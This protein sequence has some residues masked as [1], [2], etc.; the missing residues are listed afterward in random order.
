MAAPELY[1]VAGVGPGHAPALAA[2]LTASLSAAPVASV[3]LTPAEGGTLD[4]QSV[5]PL[6]D[7]VQ[8]KGVAVLIA[9]DADLA[10]AVRAD[11]V[12]LSWSRNQI[13]RYAQARETLG[14]R[15]I[16][17]A[18]AGRSRDDAMT[19]GESGADYVA[20]GI[21]PH[22]ED[23]ATAFERQCELVDW[24]TE[25]FEPPCVAL[26]ASDVAAARELARS[27]AD[28]VSVTLLADANPQDCAARVSAFAAAIASVTA[29]A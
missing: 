9:D 28:F 8:G 4:A 29:A 17:G 26:D 5:K 20:F 12:H 27:H 1:L 13:E 21:P 16:V 22:V 24:W 25:I 18:D 2:C 15:Y 23:R 19:L 11:G 6:V 7:L 10:R 3:L 14:G